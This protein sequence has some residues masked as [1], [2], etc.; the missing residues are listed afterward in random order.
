MGGLF[1]CEGTIRNNTIYGNRADFYGGGLCLCYGLVVNCIIWNNTADN[2]DDQIYNGNYPFYSCIQDGWD[3][4]QYNIASNPGF[5]D[6]LKNDFRLTVN[7]TCI[8]S[9]NLFIVTGD[10]LADM[11]GN[12]RVTGNSVDIG[13]YEWG[14]TKDTD[15]DL[16]S[17]QNEIQVGSLPDQRDTDGDGLID[18]AERFRGSDPKFPDAPTTITI[19]ADY[20]TIQEALFKSVDKERIILQPGKY[21]TNLYFT[22]CDI[23]LESTDPEDEAIRKQTILDGR[24]L[25]STITFTGSEGF[26]CIIKGLTIQ[27]GNSQNGAGCWGN[28][29][30]ATIR[31]NLIQNNFSFNGGALYG[32]DGTILENIITKTVDDI[33]G[34]GLYECNGIIRNNQILDTT[35][36][37]T[38]KGIVHCD[39]LIE[40]NTISGHQ[41]G[42]SSCDGTIQY[43]N[44]TN[45]R[46]KISFGC[47][48]NWCD[49]LIRHNVI[50]DNTGGIWN[51]KA[52]ITKNRIFENDGF[53]ISQ[54]PGLITQNQITENS[55][56]G[57][58]VCSGIIEN[59]YISK[60][61][62]TGLISCHA[63]IR[64]NIISKNSKSYIGGGGLDDCGGT[65]QNNLIIRNSSSY[66]G[67]GIN[68]CWGDFYNNVFW[69]N[70]AK[71]YA[72]ANECSGKFENCIIWNNISSN[73]TSQIDSETSPSYCCIQNW[74]VEGGSNINSNPMLSDPEHGDFHLEQGSPCIDAGKDI[75]G[76]NADF[77]GDPRPFDFLGVEKGDGSGFDIGADE[78][79]IH[80][81]HVISDH[82][83]GRKDVDPVIFSLIDYNNDSQIDITD[84]LLFFIFSN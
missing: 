53:G 43:N 60:N 39:G 59:N 13:A 81:D 77:E 36:Q 64:N 46:E 6:P 66:R 29:N 18:G 25:T 31:N 26:D 7:S 8:D 82:I 15:G 63:K 80:Y 19:P 58:Y 35:S 75:F 33:R 47:G 22:G 34:S 62:G 27:N 40:Y 76:L 73:G 28:G 74:N 3:G 71:Y 9:G 12:S 21:Q 61:R 69:G 32:C 24:G 16:L 84:L 14:A 37:V 65:I 2:F 50:T 54:C 67:G 68:N 72:A 55:L 1:Q 78:Y 10:F 70:T 38:S 49:G 48:I 4:W 52:T 17:D 44:I 20:S 11:D 45:N 51:S 23:I 5:S 56:G 30:K 42:V 79:V 41:T 83:L 57:L